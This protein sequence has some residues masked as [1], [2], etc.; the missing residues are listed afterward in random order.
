MAKYN[1][2]N[3]MPR[4][5]ANTYRQILVVQYKA[6]ELHM[7]LLGGRQVSLQEYILDPNKYKLQR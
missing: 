1:G 3:K 4:W 5:I 6:E 2:Q 7:V